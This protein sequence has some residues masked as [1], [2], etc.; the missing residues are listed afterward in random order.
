MH[1]I[2][3][4]IHLIDAQKSASKKLYKTVPGVAIPGVAI[5]WC[6]AI[7][8]TLLAMPPYAVLEGNNSPAPAS[9]FCSCNTLNSCGP[10]LD[11]P[12]TLAAPPGTKDPIEDSVPGVATPPPAGVCM[13]ETMEEIPEEDR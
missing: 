8:T 3:R 4:M 1:I 2:T 13:P 5:P 10:A 6:D 12:P 11:L 9:L 7:P